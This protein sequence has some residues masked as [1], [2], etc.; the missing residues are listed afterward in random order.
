VIKIETREIISGIHAAQR[1]GITKRRLVQLAAEGKLSAI[2][3][4]SG[5]RTYRVEDV[6]RVARQRQERRAAATK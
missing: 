2:V 1:I 3:D 5:H 4:S 6:E